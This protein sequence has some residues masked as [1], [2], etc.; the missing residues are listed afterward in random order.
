MLRRRQEQI[1][2]RVIERVARVMAERAYGSERW[3]GF[4]NLDPS[5]LPYWRGQAALA[6]D[7]FQDYCG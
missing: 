4:E 3:P 7:M 2:Y 5:I 1:D 6:L